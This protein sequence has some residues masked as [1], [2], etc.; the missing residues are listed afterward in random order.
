MPPRSLSS[1]AAVALV[2]LVASPATAQAGLYLTTGFERASYDPG[3]LD[4]FTDTYNEYYV[5]RLDAPFEYVDPS[6]VRP[7]FGVSFR[8]A[9]G[10]YA[11]GAYQFGRASQA[12]AS[13]LGAVDQRYDLTVTD[14]TVLTELGFETGPV[15]VAGVVGGV[16]RSE[17]IDYRTVYAD[18][19]ESRGNELLPTGRYTGTTPYLDAGVA[20]G[21][22]VGRVVVP[23]RVTVPVVSF[24]GVPMSD[25]DLSAFRTYFPADW[26]RY[27]EDGGGLDDGNAVHDDAFMGMRVTVGVELRLFPL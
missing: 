1:L 7:V 3:S 23:V 19:S 25:P 4:L 14:H 10:V 27:L 24:G 22:T 5:Q 17:T 16:F 20:V 21:L 12:R 15:Y 18:G 13:D 9:D 8:Y 11:S 2:A 6:L 26:D